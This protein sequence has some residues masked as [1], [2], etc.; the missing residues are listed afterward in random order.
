MATLLNMRCVSVEHPHRNIFGVHKPTLQ[1]NDIQMCHHSAAPGAPG[2]GHK[3]ASKIFTPK[4]SMNSKPLG[5]IPR[6]R[7]PRETASWSCANY[8]IASPQLSGQTTDA[9]SQEPREEP[10]GPGAKTEPL[11]VE[12]YRLTE[13]RAHQGQP[14]PAAQ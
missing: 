2:V 10:R 6:I 8:L 14:P 7:P 1:A 3:T 13:S 5:K 11:R 4:G 9:G 12:K